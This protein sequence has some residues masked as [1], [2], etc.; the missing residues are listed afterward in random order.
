MA[1]VG[2]AHLLGAGGVLALGGSLAL[3]RAAAALATGADHGDAGRIFCRALVRAAPPHHRERES[4]IYWLGGA[5]QFVVFRK[6]YLWV[7]LAV[8]LLAAATI[9]LGVLRDRREALQ[10]GAAWV[11]LYVVVALAVG[12]APGGI[13]HPK[14]G[15]MGYL[16]DRVSIYAAVLACCLLA[17][18]RPTK[19]QAAAF[20]AVAIVFFSLLY[21]DTAALDQRKPGWSKWWR[22]CAPAS[23]C[24]RPSF[25]G[26][27][28]GCTTST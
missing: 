5:D 10:R 13:F 25:R 23:A 27:G 8:V 15:M 22:P 3:M 1:L 26:A 19:W 9:A 20:S 16:P 17:L 7:A 11:Q 21:A 12:L 28:P 18:A 4:D 6:A 14:L 2:M 24:W